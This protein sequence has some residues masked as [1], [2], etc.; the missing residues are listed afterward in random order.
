MALFKVIDAMNG[1]H[2]G[3]ILRLKLIE[4]D[5]PTVRALRGALLEARSPEGDE[6]HRVRVD[7]FPLFGGKPSDSRI[8]KTGR[9]DVHVFPENGERLAPASLQWEVEGPLG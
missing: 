2:G 3:R 5:P 6:V 9:V 1:P 8:R 7:G 4:G